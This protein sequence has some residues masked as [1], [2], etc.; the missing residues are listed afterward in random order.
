VSHRHDA[1]RKVLLKVLGGVSV[2]ALLSQG[3]LGPLADARASQA[4]AS[5]PAGE[6]VE[7]RIRPVG[8]VRIKGQVADEAPVAQAA[9]VE[10]SGAEVYNLACAACHGTGA[11]GAPKIGDQAAWAPRLEQGFDTLASHAIGG[12][13]A[14]PPR[15]GN[16]TLTDLEVKRS[17]AHMVGQVGMKVSLPAPEPVAAPAAPAPAPA[18]AGAAPA[19]GAAAPAATG[20]ADLARGETIYKQACFACHQMGVVG[21]PKLGDKQAWAPRLAQGLDTLRQHALQGIRGMPPKGGRTDLADEA[22]IDA[23]AYMVQQSS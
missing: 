17:V 1:V 16:P 9:A 2:F 5:A 3:G 15:G 8:K 21:A 19:P 20:D 13:K 11:A 6:T 14:M 7:D 10:R 4:S 18:P 22:V 12:F 23:V